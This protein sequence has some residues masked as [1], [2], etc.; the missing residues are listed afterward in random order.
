M[1]EQGVAEATPFHHFP[2]VTD[3]ALTEAGYLSVHFWRK[4]SQ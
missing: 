2:A 4:S 1:K 3:T